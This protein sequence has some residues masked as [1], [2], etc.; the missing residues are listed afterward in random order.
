MGLTRLKKPDND[1]VMNMELKNI[2]LPV[3]GI[4]FFLLAAYAVYQYVLPSLGKQGE[5]GEVMEKIYLKSLEVG[6]GA[7]NY[8]Y[9]YQE[10][11]AGY[12]MRSTLVQS[13]GRQMAVLETPLAMKKFYYMENDTIMC[14]TFEGREACAS[15]YN[16]TDI[17]KYAK[18]LKQQFFAPSQIDAQKQMAET[19]ISKKAITFH[20]ETEIEING[21]ACKD[22]TFTID[23]SNLTLDDLILFGITSSSPNRIEGE[24]CYDETANEIY[25]KSYTYQYRGKEATTEFALIRT[26]WNYTGRI[27]AG[28]NLTRAAIDIYLDASGK[29]NQLLSCLA[30]ATPEEKDRCVFSMALGNGYSTLCEYAGTKAG[31]CTLN[32]AA[33]RKDPSMCVQ[34]ADS[35]TKDDC[36]FEVAGAKHDATVCSSI[37]DQTKVAAC[38]QAANSNETRVPVGEG[39]F[40]NN[41]TDNQTEPLP[42]N[43]TAE[44]KVALE[45]ILNE[46][47]KD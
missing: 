47:G 6:T 46:L 35:A 44:E 29:E 2:L 28:S 5:E 11:L 9:Q 42:S 14:I 32:F 25:R 1:F 15:L 37:A 34:I 26:D 20:K 4:A 8:F 19:L 31:I 10:D 30:S 38:V 27:E 21:K 18:W 22:I 33:A 40:I 43:M 39:I 3:L 23:Y 13:G 24:I 12:K 41:Q 45:K 7:G 16:Q 36:Y 17:T